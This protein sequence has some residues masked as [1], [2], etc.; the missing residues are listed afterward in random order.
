MWKV[1]LTKMWMTASN[2]L[3]EKK[4][5]KV[6]KSSS[7]KGGRKTRWSQSLSDLVDIIISSEYYKKKL[8]FTNTKNQKNGE[9]YAQILV[10]PKEPASERGEEV[11]FTYIQL[12]TKFKKAIAECKKAAL[13]IKTATGIKRFIEE[14]S[15]GAWF[16][17]L[18]SIVKIC[19]A[20]RPELA[21]LNHQVQE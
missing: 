7:K 8:I 12:R 17:D 16:N 4:T 15:Y 21:I 2:F 5:P 10:T 19:A 9:I 18:F 1:T 11:P 3:L 6:K 20:C 13:T 14:K